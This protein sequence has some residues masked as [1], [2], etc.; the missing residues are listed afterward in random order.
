M[1][2]AGNNSIVNSIYERHMSPGWSKCR[3]DSKNDERTTW[4]RAKYVAQLFSIPFQESKFISHR[5]NNFVESGAACV[6]DIFAVIGPSNPEQNTSDYLNRPLDSVKFHPKALAIYP[7]QLKEEYRA[8]PDS[9]VDYVFPNGVRLSGS[10]K[11]PHYFTFVMV[12]ATGLKLYGATL[13][14]Y[15]LLEADE[16]AALLGLSVRSPVFP[17]WPLVFAPKALTIVS[18]YAF[19]NLFREYLEQ[20]YRISLSSSPLPIERYIVNFVS[21]IPLPPRGRVEVHYTLP[22]RVICVTRPPKNQLPMVDFSYRPLLT[23]LSV[24]N[25]ILVF[26]A[27]CCER[28]LCFFSETI[29]ILTPIQEAFLSFLFPLVWQGTYIPVLPTKRIDALSAK[30]PVLVG[31]HKVLL[32]RLVGHSDVLFVD[33]DQ[34]RVIFGKDLNGTVAPTPVALPSKDEAKLRVALTSQSLIVYHRKNV[35][36][37]GLAFPRKEHLNPIESFTGG[38]SIASILEG[39]GAGNNCTVG[40]TGESVGRDT[41]AP[42]S[43]PVAASSSSSV[44]KH[45]V[46]CTRSSVHSTSILDPN[47]NVGLSDRFSASDVRG[48]FLRFFVSVLRVYHEYVGAAKISEGESDTSSQLSSTTSRTSLFGIFH[49]TSASSGDVVSSQSPFIAQL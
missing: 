22:D 19:F 20:L 46:V 23:C 3:H 13:H 29:A 9:L 11:D 44:S 12:T 47:N 30:V 38:F 32:D 25:I 2:K 35:A 48:A 34:D 14:V 27:L 4:I 5:I 8:I 15:E 49:H 6:S 17:K 42:A 33:L 16:L 24:D 7:T 21:E 26:R 28:K 39:G 36:T 10:E 45:P 18:K 41:N 37:A 40:A 31:V 1:K 43:R